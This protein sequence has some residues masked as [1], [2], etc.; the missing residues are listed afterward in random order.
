MVIQAAAHI[1][2]PR[3]AE[4]SQ[5]YLCTDPVHQLLCS[6]HPWAG[7]LQAVGGDFGKMLKFPSFSMSNRMSPTVFCLQSGIY[8]CDGEEG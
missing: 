3:R 6:K 1:Y 7:S 8:V 2:L 5:I 4:W